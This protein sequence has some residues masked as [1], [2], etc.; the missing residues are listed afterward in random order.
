MKI[1]LNQTLVLRLNF[2]QKPIEE[3]AGKVTKTV[4]NTIAY[5]LTDTHREA[6]I[7]FSLKV[8]KTKKTYIIQRRHGTKIIKV[9]VGNVSDYTVD[10][11]RNRA[12]DIAKAIEET[13]TNPNV[14]AR[15]IH[16]AE[17]SIGECFSR[18]R[19]Y[20]KNKPCKPTTLLTLDKCLKNLI[21]WKD[22]KVKDL[23]SEMILNRFDEIFKVHKTT[24][25]QTFN[26]ANASIAY[27]L[28]HE[29]FEAKKAGRI[30]SLTINPLEILKI[31][32]KFRSKKQLEA[33]YE[34][35]GIRKPLS[36]RDTM[37]P[38]LNAVWGRRKENRTGCDFILC[39]LLW[40]KLSRKQRLCMLNS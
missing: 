24:A 14:L 28:K 39:S 30:P 34:A 25:E 8:A 20:L 11:A 27:C 6:P 13:G 9:K 21:D 12:R 10:A 35:K 33:S 32:N 18:Y 1:E 40:G 16:T 23:S 31:E 17:L 3:K 19:E 29:Q 5:I 37:G 7:G 22:I 2:D 26:W 38:F 4:P 36:V 15:E